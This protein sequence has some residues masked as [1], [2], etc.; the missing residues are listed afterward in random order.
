MLIFYLFFVIYGC[1]RV[2]GFWPVGPLHRVH[3]VVSTL[4]QNRQTVV[5]ERTF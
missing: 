5:P 4:D 2:F 1:K 3:H